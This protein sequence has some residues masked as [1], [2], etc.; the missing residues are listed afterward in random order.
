VRVTYFG[1]ACTLIEVGGRK[2]LTDPWL[3]EG[4]YFGTWFH[5]HL[6]A[7]AGVSPDTFPKD[8]DYIFLAHEHEDHVDPERLR[9]FPPNVPVLICKFPTPR[10]RHYLESLGLRNI[11]EI[12]SSQETN[13]ASGVSVTI[14]GTAEYTNDVLR[15]CV[16][17]EEFYMRELMPKKIAVD[18]QYETNAPSGRTSSCSSKSF[19]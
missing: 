18:L 7:D 19:Y 13:L 12:A 8:I 4:A 9:H 11:R 1:Q 3:T 5:T 10:F 17:P 15:H 2:I 14:F 16:N 6:L